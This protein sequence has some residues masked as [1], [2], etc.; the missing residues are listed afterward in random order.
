MGEEWDILFHHVTS[1]DDVLYLHP[2][3][4]ETWDGPVEPGC[5]RLTEYVAIPEYYG[6][7]PLQAGETMQA[8]AYVYGHPDLPEDSC[9]PEGDYQLRTNGIAGD[10]EE[11]ISGGTGG[12]E[13]DWSF[14]L[15][16]G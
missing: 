4:E 15:Q 11:S 1:G 2:A 8:D 14:T 5:W 12:T 16:V 13:F 6:T 10:D 7:I 3:S 9:L